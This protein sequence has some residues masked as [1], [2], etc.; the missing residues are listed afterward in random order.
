MRRDEFLALLSSESFDEVVTVTR[1]PNGSLDLH[2]HPFEAKALILE[3]DL[4]IRIAAHARTYR[5]GDIFHLAPNIE[6]S[7]QYG[8]E[9]VSYLVG[10]K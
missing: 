2:A 8:P 6:H 4:T 7:E 10:R 5:A 3:G 9:G 1:E